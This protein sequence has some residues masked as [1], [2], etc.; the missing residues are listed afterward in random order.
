MNQEVDLNSMYFEI[1]NECIRRSGIAVGV[2]FHRQACDFLLAVLDVV[3][4]MLFLTLA[5]RYR[6]TTN[7]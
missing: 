3:E 1:K 7:L 5:K 2:S 6:A 4:V